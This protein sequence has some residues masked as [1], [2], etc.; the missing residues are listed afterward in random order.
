[1][2]PKSNNIVKIP[3]QKQYESDYNKNDVTDMDQTLDVDFGVDNSF[4]VD[5][6]AGYNINRS[7]HLGEDKDQD[8]TDLEYMSDDQLEEEKIGCL[9]Y[10]AR[11]LSSC[12]LGHHEMP[13]E[14]A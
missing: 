13:E 9:P 14:V 8:I 1:M 3:N 4:E 2:M 6:I 7:S 12:I 10:S 11:S 5:D